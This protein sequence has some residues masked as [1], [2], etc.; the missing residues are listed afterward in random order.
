MDDMDEKYWEIKFREFATTLMEY[1]IFPIL[2]DCKKHFRF[3][4]T[5][6]IQ[7]LVLLCI[8]LIYV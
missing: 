3:N 2:R 4:P 6:N 5:V 7:I 8:N 1:P